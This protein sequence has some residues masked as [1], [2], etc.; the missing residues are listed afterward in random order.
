MYLFYAALHCNLCTL[1]TFVDTHMPCLFCI[2]SMLY[3]VSGTHNSGATVRFIFLSSSRSLDH[4]Q[5][6]VD[7]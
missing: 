7:C 4:C 3:A 2:F 1:S 5:F 6:I